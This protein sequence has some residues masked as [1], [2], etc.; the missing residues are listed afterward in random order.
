ME[1]RLLGREPVITVSVVTAA[2]IAVLPVFGWPAEIVGVVAGALVVL[3]G[4]TEAALIS[5]DRLLPLLVGVGKAV[6]AVLAA[7]G[8]HLADN[9]V[10]AVMALLTVVA[11]LQMRQQVVPQ[12]R[13]KWHSDSGAVDL[14]R[15]DLL[16]YP[17]ESARWMTSE[18]RAEV[19][20]EADEPPLPQ[21][22]PHGRERESR[23]RD[24]G[25]QG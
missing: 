10:S 17:A 16:R 14:P 11:G 20:P 1:N 12:Q 24:R 9:H 8:L 23:G 2:L 13:P 18:L 21:A 3:G 25:N 4:A 22:E 6:L 7:F 19:D 15:V 5:V